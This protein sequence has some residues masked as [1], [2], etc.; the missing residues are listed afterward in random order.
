MNS[1]SF[2]L[3]VAMVQTLL[4][5]SAGPPV[6]PPGRL[7][8]KVLRQNNT[9]AQ[10]ASPVFCA[11]IVRMHDPAARCTGHRHGGLDPD[12][13]RR[14]CARFSQQ[15]HPH[16]R[17]VHAGR[18]QRRAGAR[19]RGRLPGAPEAD[20]RRRQQAGWRRHHRLRVRREV[21]AGRLHVDDRAG[22][23]HHGAAPVAQAG[24]T[25]RSPNSR[26]SISWP[27]FPSSWSCRRACR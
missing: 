18:L 26:R 19:T 7:W 24:S 27:T 13:P 10:A 11:A 3:R 23:V 12:R 17:A 5:R 4:D 21:A 8:G 1:P 15:D 2:I 16:R 9:T 6:W 22:L 14:R 25:I 20:R